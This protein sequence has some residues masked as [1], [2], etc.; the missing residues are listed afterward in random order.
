[1]KLNNTTIVLRY[2]YITNLFAKKLMPKLCKND[3]ETTDKIYQQKLI[4]TPSMYVQ[5]DVCFTSFT[6]FV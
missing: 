4:E 3:F 2:Y 1:M 6:M 5:N